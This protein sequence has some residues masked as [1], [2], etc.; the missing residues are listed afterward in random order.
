M[1][2]IGQL[3]KN[4]GVKVTTI[5]YYEEIGVL[6]EPERTQGHQRRYD[7]AALERL[8]FVK[9][10]RD[11]G[12]TIQAIESLIQLQ[13]SPEKS[14][15]EATDIANE[16]L[17]DVRRRIKQLRSLEKELARIVKGCSGE[18]TSQSCYVLAALA[19]HELCEKDH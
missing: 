18:G 11:L 16:Q 1:Y 6:T 5:R 2:S 3:S 12:F 13:E 10:A 17:L 7:V 14:C 4:T 15:K 9:H 8:R 19:D